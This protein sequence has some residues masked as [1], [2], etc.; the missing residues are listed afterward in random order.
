MI[1]IIAKCDVQ[2]AFTFMD[3]TGKN[4]LVYKTDLILMM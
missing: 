2:C 1:Y 4:S 3:V